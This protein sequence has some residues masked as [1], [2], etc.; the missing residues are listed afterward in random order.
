[1]SGIDGGGTG[2]FSDIEFLHSDFG[3]ILFGVVDV[4][5]VVPIAGRD[6]FALDGEVARPGSSTS[7]ISATR[8]ISIHCQVPN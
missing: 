4:L 1:L 7:Y 6:L 3:G 5:A 8:T 2:L